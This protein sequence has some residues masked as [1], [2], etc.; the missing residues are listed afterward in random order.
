MEIYFGEIHSQII[1]IIN[2]TIIKKKTLR[3]INKITFLDHTKELFTSNKILRLDNTLMFNLILY[4]IY[5][6]KYILL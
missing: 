5:H 4:I 3:I 2:T 1:K 6:F